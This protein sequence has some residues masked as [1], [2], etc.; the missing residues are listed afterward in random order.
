MM[1]LM[2]SVGMVVDNSIVV[3]E[4]IYTKRSEGKKGKAA[5]LWGTSEVSLAITMATFTTI[6]VFLP[7][8]LMS[9]NVGFK[10]YMLRI[11]VPVMVSLLASLIV[12]MVLF[13]LLLQRLSVSVR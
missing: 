4:N 8:I 6:V 9:D 2:V 3:L 7:L 11:G 1:G 5:S 13:R 10:F 12:A